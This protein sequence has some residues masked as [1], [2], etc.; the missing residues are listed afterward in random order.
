MSLVSPSAAGARGGV[1][2]SVGPWPV[3][4]G[5]VS[6]AVSS[7]SSYAWYP[8]RYQSRST[9]TVHNTKA[10]FETKFRDCAC[11]AAQPLSDASLD[12]VLEAIGRLEM[13]PDVREL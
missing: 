7:G 8:A 4:V 11:N 2:S 9:P 6:H 10:Q 12:A 3:T 13:L 1:I 5:G